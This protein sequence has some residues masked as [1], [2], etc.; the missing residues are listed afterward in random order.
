MT[1]VFIGGS[2]AVSRLTSV[3][4]E[5]LDLLVARGDMILVGDANGAD[6][7]VQQHL[8]EQDYTKV[9]V[10]CMERC[11]NNIGNWETSMLVGD[12]SRVKDF[13]YYAIKDKAMADRATCG[14]ML[15]DGKS[16]GTLNN[17]QNLLHDDK[18]V[19]VYLAPQKAFFKLTNQQELDQL[20]QT[21]NAWHDST[22][23]HRHHHKDHPRPTQLELRASHSAA[24]SSVPEMRQRRRSS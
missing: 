2:R 21:C 12:G 18:P 23:D 9:V 6:K 24:T 20:L 13:H 17:V 16:R 3:L 14:I 10:F 15:W 1:T 5:K 7:A 19:L 11:R 22:R 4:K 8:A